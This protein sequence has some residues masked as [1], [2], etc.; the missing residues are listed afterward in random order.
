MQRKSERFHNS[1]DH[2]LT[3]VAILTIA[4][5]S[6]LFW[7]LILSVVSMLICQP[8]NC[9]RSEQSELPPFR[10]GAPFEMGLWGRERG[11]WTR[12]PIQGEYQAA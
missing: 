9:D 8:T 3:R 11:L 10:T 6:L 7:T 4:G 1:I 12:S 5:L 2:R